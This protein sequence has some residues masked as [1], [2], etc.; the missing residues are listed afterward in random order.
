MRAAGA[1][2]LGITVRCNSLLCAPATEPLQP[3]LLSASD[4]LY[5]PTSDE[6]RGR[7]LPTLMSFMA[8]HCASGATPPTSCTPRRSSYGRMTS[9]S[10]RLCGRTCDRRSRRGNE[11]STELAE[12]GDAEAYHNVAALAAPLSRSASAAAAP[13]ERSD[14][15]PQRA[16]TL[17]SVWQ[18]G[19]ESGHITLQ[20]SRRAMRCPARSKRIMKWRACCAHV[21]GYHGRLQLLVRR[22]ARRRPMR[23][24]ARACP[25]AP[26]QPTHHPDSD[27][28][29]RAET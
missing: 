17:V 12:A 26:P 16:K 3:R 11:D 22:L 28:N 2:I 8:C 21:S 14:L 7:N 13:R 29:L 1:H 6:Q 19:L 18:V 15:S 4:E 5:S 24:R 20:F 9:M 23:A 27:T 25:H 10:A